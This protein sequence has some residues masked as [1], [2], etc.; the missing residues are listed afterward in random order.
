MKT[1]K[2]G[3]LKKHCCINIAHT[4]KKKDGAI[5]LLQHKIELLNGDRGN[6][7]LDIFSSKYNL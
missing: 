1:N 2:K 7:L 5:C 3:I 4:K 6:K